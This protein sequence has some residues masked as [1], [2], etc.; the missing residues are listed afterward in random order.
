MEVSDSDEEI[1]DINEAQTNSKTIVKKE[2]T[3][4]SSLKKI[5]WS[6]TNFS[7]D[8]ISD[9]VKNN[10]DQS[11]FENEIKTEKGEENNYNEKDQENNIDNKDS[12]NDEDKISDIEK[13]SKNNNTSF[14]YTF[15]WEEGGNEVKI[16]GSFSNWKDSYEMKKDPNDNI[17]KISL[18]LNNEKYY[19]KFIVDGQWK[20]ARNQQT[21][22]DEAGNINNFLDLSNFFYKI[23][24]DPTPN[25]PKKNKS[26]K[27]MKKKS[28]KLSNKTKE[29]KL[30]KESD[31][32]GMENF[33]INQMTE[34]T[35]ND[36]IGNPL[37]LYNESKKYA[38][39]N[40]KFYGFSQ[41]KIFSSYKSYLG[42]SG[43]RH[44]TLNHVLL[45]KTV[46][47]AYDIRVG[48]SHRYREKATTIIYYNCSSKIKN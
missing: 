21:K 29:K 41:S 10:N 14:I 45:P 12:N 47:N 24:T 4:K 11:F 43:Y 30:K 34:P 33:D 3:S 1:A 37:N 35:K 15:I 44:D 18:S 40:P 38:F 28:S 27:K 9:I 39:G 46:E 32:F 19:Y 31:E 6:K 42:L 17:Y 5:Y 13:E 48:I 25:I 7:V 2:K 8:S 26:K 36:L 16:I 23:N 20:Y 22:E